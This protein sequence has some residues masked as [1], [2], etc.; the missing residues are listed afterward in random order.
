MDRILSASQRHIHSSANIFKLAQDAFRFALPPM[1]QPSAAHI[2]PSTDA[3]AEDRSQTS[4]NICCR[5]HPSRSNQTTDK[6]HP[7]CER[8]NKDLLKVSFELGIQV[9]RM[10]LTSLNWKRREMV[11]Y[12]LT[13]MQL[14]FS[15]NNYNIKH[16]S[17]VY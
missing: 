9:M 17:N 2:A 3:R 7:M 11:R 14:L 15:L 16:M 13:K 6:D 5:E 1:P 10:T 12:F 4:Q 8:G